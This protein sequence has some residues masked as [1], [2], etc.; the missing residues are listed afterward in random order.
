VK[1]KDVKNP[2]PISMT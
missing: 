2:L 1:N